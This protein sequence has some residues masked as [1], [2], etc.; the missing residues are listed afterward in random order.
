MKLGRRCALLT[1]LL[2]AAVPASAVPAAL[3]SSYVLERYAR[4]LDSLKAPHAAI[5][6]YAVSQEGPNNLEQRHQVY[7]SGIDVRDET[8]S[9]DGAAIRPKVVRFGEREDRYAIARIAPRASSYGF[10]F[11]RTAKNGARTDYLY[12]T[13]PL[14]PGTTGFLVSGVAIDSK[15]FLPH[16]VRFTSSSGVA[17]AAGAIEYA[18]LEGYVVPVAVNVAANLGGKPAREHLSFGAYRFPPSLPAS[19]FVPPQPLTHANPTP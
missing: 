14:E 2:L 16:V 1:I 15:T 8:I 10:I 6:Q 5:F 9:I 12:E 11:L 3:D 4:A 18:S 13:T 7:R 17:S 19:T